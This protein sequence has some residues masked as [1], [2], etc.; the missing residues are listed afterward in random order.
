VTKLKAKNTFE[1]HWFFGIVEGRNDPLEAGRLQVRIYGRHTAD[2]V[3]DQFK[4]IPSEELIWSQ[5]IN[6][7][8]SASVSGVGLTPNGP[9]E[10]SMVFGFFL[11]G[12]LCQLPYIM[13]T[14]DGIPVAS[15]DP[16]QGF[17][18]P[19]GLYPKFL[20]E[21]DVNRLARSAFRS[22]PGLVSK[23]AG[24]ITGIPVAVDNVAGTGVPGSA[25]TLGT[26]WDEP[27]PANNTRYPYN[28]VRETESGHVEEYDDSPGAERMHWMHGTTGT[29]E[30]WQPDGSVSQ[31]ITEDQ[32]VIVVGGRNILV[33]KDQQITILGNAK[34]LVQGNLQEQVNGNVT[35]LIKG[36]LSEK[37]EGN[38]ARDILGESFVNT[39][40]N[41]TQRDGS[42]RTEV[43][44]LNK[45]ESIGSN[46]SL[47]IGAQNSIQCLGDWTQTSA[48]SFTHI[49]GGNKTDMV[50]GNYG[51]NVS[52]A[53]GL[54]CATFSVGVSG[55]AT[56]DATGPTAILGSRIDLN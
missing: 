47:Q 39:Q 8:Q 44:A 2:K 15:S 10:G 29:Y 19:K 22:H 20:N 32:T 11:D 28:H 42:N 49:T 56:I 54:A 33:G 41:V 24:R 50:G 31:K 34:I 43:I 45:T 5:S 25:D 17:N 38:Y 6:S 12:N 46:N 13:G 52:S 26:K 37:I 40:G 23:T 14:I 36:N 1:L 53:Y 55:A 21:P 7:I 9:V 3:K 35:R 48:T 16:T 30:E 27:A 4:G 51:I 18:D